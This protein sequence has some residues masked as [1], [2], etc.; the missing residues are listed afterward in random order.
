[1]LLPKCASDSIAD[2]SP[3]GATGIHKRRYMNCAPH[4]PLSHFSHHAE[5]V[6][7]QSP[8]LYIPIF[9]RP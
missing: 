3:I 9:T 7:P 8:F 2:I 1:M 6:T 5:G 4:L